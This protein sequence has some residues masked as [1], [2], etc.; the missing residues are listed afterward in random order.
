MAIGRPATTAENSASKKG[1]IMEMKLEKNRYLDLPLRK[2]GRNAPPVTLKEIAYYAEVDISVVSRVINGKAEKYRISPQCQEKVKKVAVEL[3]YIP[4]AYAIGMKTGEFHCVALLQSGAAGKSYLP[5]KLINEIHRTLEK[6]DRHLLL[7]NIP[8]KGGRGGDMPKIF[9]S[10]MADGLIVNYYQDLPQKIR[11]A[12][13]RTSMPTVWMNDRK[14][15]NAVYPDSFSAAKKATEYLIEL[16]HKRISYC[17]VYFNDRRPNAH[18]SVAERREG[19]AEAIKNASLE[20]L[21]ITPDYPVDDSME[22]QTELFYSILEKPDRPTAMLFYW[23]FSIPAVLMA[24]SRL[25]L[26]IPNDLSILTFASESHQRI[27]LTATAMLEPETNMGR[28]AVAMLSKKIIA[29]EI[30]SPSIKLDYQFLDMGTCIR[31]KA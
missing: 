21:D 26:L 18:Y 20:N 29:R 6:E 24:A 1:N 3:G 31:C 30:V 5:E 10:L 23:S 11:D 8:E 17:N 15:F 22:K 28:E 12:I 27:G 13:E 4:N 7:A 16:G 19:Y 9:R 25:N 14:E 2:R